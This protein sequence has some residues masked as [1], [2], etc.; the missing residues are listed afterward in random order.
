MERLV[1]A[2]PKVRQL[3]AVGVLRVAVPLGVTGLSHVVVDLTAGSPA[4]ETLIRA[5]GKEGL[6]NRRPTARVAEQIAQILSA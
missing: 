2:I 3:P 5:Y 4:G 1:A 6:L